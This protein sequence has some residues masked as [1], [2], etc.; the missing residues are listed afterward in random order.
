MY[1]GPLQLQ[2]GYRKEEITMNEVKIYRIK[3]LAKILKVTERTI[4]TYCEKQKIKAV[5]VGGKWTVTHDNLMAFLNG[6]V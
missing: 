3:E 6:G 4:L 1:A 2:T 5:K